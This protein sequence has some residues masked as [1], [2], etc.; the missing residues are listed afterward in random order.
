VEEVVLFSKAN[1]PYIQARINA[2]HG[3]QKVE[4]HVVFFPFTN[5]PAGE[6]RLDE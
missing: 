5:Q 4:D 2:G 1:D 3:Y 6:R